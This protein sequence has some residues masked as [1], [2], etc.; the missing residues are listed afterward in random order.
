MIIWRYL[1]EGRIVVDGENPYLTVS[2]NE[3][4]TY[5]RDSTPWSKINHKEITSIY[6][7]LVQEFFCDIYCP[8]SR[9]DRPLKLFL[10]SPILE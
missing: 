7:P 5:L 3:K 9:D 8:R 10:R 2:A 1:W 4:L 6:P